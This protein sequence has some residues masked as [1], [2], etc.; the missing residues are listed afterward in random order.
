[1]LMLP[2]IHCIHWVF[3]ICITNVILY[4]VNGTQVFPIP[5]VILIA[6]GIDIVTWIIALVM[7]DVPQFDDI[8]MLSFRYNGR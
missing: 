4:I 2:F 3:V 1:M 5:Y 8:T 6:L 7:G